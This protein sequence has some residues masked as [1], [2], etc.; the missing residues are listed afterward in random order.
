VEAVALE[1]GYAGASAFITMF[2][3]LMGTTPDEFRRGGGA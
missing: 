2:K 3:R 1:L